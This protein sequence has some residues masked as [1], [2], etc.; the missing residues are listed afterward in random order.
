[1]QIVVSSDKSIPNTELSVAGHVFT[2]NFWGAN[3]IVVKKRASLCSASVCFSG[4]FGTSEKV[5]LPPQK[6]FLAGRLG[7]EP[8]LDVRAAPLPW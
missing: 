2:S 5:G 7:L 1:M 4:V 6:N 3:L 8:L